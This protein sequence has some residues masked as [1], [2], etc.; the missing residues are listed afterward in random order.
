[1][2]GGFDLDGRKLNVR[3]GQQLVSWGESTFIPNG[4]NV[5]NPV[6][7]TR[8]RAPGSELKE[9][10][11]PQPM[12]WAA[13]QLS[14]RLTLEG[15]YQFKRRQLEIDPRGSFFSTNDFISDDGDRVSVGFG[16]RNDQHGAPGI[17]GVT[18]RRRD[19]RPG[20]RTGTPM[21][22]GNSDWRCA[23]CCRR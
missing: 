18:R 12:I 10:L 5:I 6:N 8:L 14:D 17:F 3:L 9:A 4:I 20:Q 7:L 23:G 22:A 13:Q 16:R 11:M 15:F 19:G 1:M 21:M 2:Y